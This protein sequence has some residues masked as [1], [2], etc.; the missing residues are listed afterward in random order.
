MDL[1]GSSGAPFVDLMD[2]KSVNK[3]ILQGIIVYALLG[4]SPSQSFLIKDSICIFIRLTTF[5]DNLTHR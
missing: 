4:E 1:F 3:L 2:C 5:F